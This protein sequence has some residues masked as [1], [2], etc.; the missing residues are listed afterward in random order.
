M[1]EHKRAFHQGQLARE[2]SVEYNGECA[3][4][5]REERSLPGLTDILWIVEHN[6]AL[7]NGCG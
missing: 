3:D 6:E 2:D 1:Q 5:Y 7:D 4:P